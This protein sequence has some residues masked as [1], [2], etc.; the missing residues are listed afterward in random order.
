M[1]KL[2]IISVA[3]VSAAATGALLRWMPFRGIPGANTVA[4][5]IW[6]AF[7]GSLLCVGTWFAFTAAPYRV[8]LI[9]D[10][11]PC[12]LRILHIQKHGLSFRET[13]VVLSQDGRYFSSVADRR[14]FEYEIRQA[15]GRGLMP[16]ATRERVSRLAQSTALWAMHTRPIH[17]LG[18]WNAE[19]WYVVVK[20]ARLV[21]F[22]SEDPKS[23]MQD[24]KE[25]FFEVQSLPLPERGLRSICDVCLGLCYG[26]AAALGFVYSNQPCFALAYGKS[27]CG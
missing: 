1:A 25:L 16:A 26:P 12:E 9:V 22:A 24:V 15:V 5:S 8:P 11:G 6:P 17:I 27:D 18:S 14:L 21:T 19:A 4:Q 2:Q 20:D 10:S 3:L 13:A 23:Q 7:A